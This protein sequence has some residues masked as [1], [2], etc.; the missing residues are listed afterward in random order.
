MSQE[1][2]GWE[3]GLIV[4]PEIQ[5]KFTKVRT[6]PK[7]QAGYGTQTSK[8][9]FSIEKYFDRN[10][11]PLTITTVP[12]PS[13]DELISNIVA[14]LGRN[15]DVVLCYNSQCLF[16]DGDIEHVS[17]IEEFNKESGQVTVVD[18]AIG[19]P[20]RRVTTIFEIFKTMQHNNVCEIGGFW[21][22]SERE[23]ST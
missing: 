20:K 6:G 8:P 10:N 4:P 2:I 19:A 11:L 22:I 1:E 12:P 5:L 7:P 21:I 15:N 14:A 13:L 23:Q 3:L 16:G 18:P 17:L 9:E